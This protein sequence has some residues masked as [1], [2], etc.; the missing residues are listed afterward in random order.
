MVLGWCRNNTFLL[1]EDNGLMWLA[2]LD[3]YS[4][5]SLCYSDVFLFY[6][7]FLLKEDHK[8]LNVMLYLLLSG[9]WIVVMC[10]FN[11]YQKPKWTVCIINL[12]QQSCFERVNG[13]VFSSFFCIT[14]FSFTTFLSYS[15]SQKCCRN[16]VQ[17]ECM[18][19]T[20]SIQPLLFPSLTKSGITFRLGSKPMCWLCLLCKYYMN[21]YIYIVIT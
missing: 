3:G 2:K 16:D 10:L 1:L 20:S 11:F 6:S 9:F 14:A 19:A 18:N 4:F 12:L 8:A 5:F 17:N 13:H 15:V 21:N 7:I